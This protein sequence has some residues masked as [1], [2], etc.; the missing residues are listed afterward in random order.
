MGTLAHPNPR[1]DNDAESHIDM[2]DGVV[3]IHQSLQRVDGTLRV[4]CRLRLEHRRHELRHRPVWYG[5]SPNIGCNSAKNDWS[6]GSL[7][8]VLISCSHLRRV[9]R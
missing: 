6:W 2:K 5:F 9:P 1:T 3:H 8:P 7:G 4:W